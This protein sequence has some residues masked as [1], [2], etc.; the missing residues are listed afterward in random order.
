V[1]AQVAV[2]LYG[3]E[4]APGLKLARVFLA[5]HIAS[6]SR[7]GSGGQLIASSAG[8]LSRSFAPVMSK[9]QLALT[10]YGQLYLALL[11]PVARGPQVL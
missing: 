11:P 5:A 2:S 7:L 4:S 8:G 9:S 10:Q 6:A 1:N 3:G